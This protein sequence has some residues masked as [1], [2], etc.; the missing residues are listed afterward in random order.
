MQ[1]QKRDKKLLKLYE[2]GRM[3]HS[4]GKLSQSEKVFRKVIKLNPDFAPAQNNL[5][6]VLLDLGRLDHAYQAYM[7][8]LDLE[9]N[10]PLI[11]NNIGNVLHLQKRHSEAIIFLKRAIDLKPDYAEAY[12]N[13]GNA[14]SDS[15]DLN[16]AVKYYKKTIKLNPQAAEAYHNLGIALEELGK[17]E[18]AIEN[19]SRVIEF[20]PK[21]CLTYRHLSYLKIYELGDPHMNSMIALLDDPTL[22]LQ[23]K[24]HLYFSLGKAYEDT[25]DYNES[26]KYLEMANDLQKKILNFKINSELQLSNNIKKY[27]RSR[28]FKINPIYDKS[29]SF[30]QIFIVGMPRSGTSLIEQILASHS[31]VFG[32][33]EIETCNQYL[34]PFFSSKSIANS[35]IKNEDACSE[36][37][38]NLRTDYIQQIT[39]FN[40]KE[41]Y[42]VDKMPLNFLW[43]GVIREIF[44]D[45]KIIHISR[46]PIA[47][48]WSIYKT[49]FPARGLDFAYN[50]SDLSKFYKMYIELMEFWSDNLNSNIYQISYEALTEN[51]VEETKKLLNF[52]ELDWQSECL[53]FH[54][55]ARV[56]KTASAVQVRKKMYKGSSDKWKSYKNHLREFIDSLQS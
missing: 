52:C 29:I 16:Q 30:R 1:T 36:V 34:R 56:V 28:P 55:T 25:H 54:K 48:C 39:S 31:N 46:D 3:L 50:L 21:A 10:Y 33:G 19:Y 8:A 53:N 41:D 40:L 11:I 7:R 37:F 15:G 4:N 13:L 5:G 43:I 9:P 12:Y 38:N 44:P 20:N 17:F 27:F 2:E 26:F 18:D 42:V 22:T 49:Y 51:Q 47:T 35:I 23:D 24:I 6:N 45:A 32:A 14:F